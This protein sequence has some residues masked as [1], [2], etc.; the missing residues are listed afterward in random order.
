MLINKKK[1]QK[2]GKLIGLFNKE[3][4]KRLSSSLQLKLLQYEP[5][6]KS[7]R[8]KSNIRRQRLRSNIRIRQLKGRERPRRLRRRGKLG[9]GFIRRS[10]R[11]K[12]RKKKSVL[13]NS[14]LID[15]FRKKRSFKRTR[16]KREFKLRSRRERM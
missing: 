6:H 13:Y 8:I 10:S 12:S 14:K 16:G 2:K 3:Q 11:K 15:S 5:V 1:R 9:E 7:Q 4:P